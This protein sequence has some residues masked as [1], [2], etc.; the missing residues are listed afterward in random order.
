MEMTC[1]IHSTPTIRK[2]Y[3]YVIMFFFHDKIERIPT[4]KAF[5]Q[6]Y[7][8]S[9]VKKKARTHQDRLIGIEFFYLFSVFSTGKFYIIEFTYSQKYYYFRVILRDEFKII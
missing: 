6:I 5:V 2:M 4:Y 8:S 1:D 9:S 3:M 7:H